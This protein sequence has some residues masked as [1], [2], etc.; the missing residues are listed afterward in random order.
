VAWVEVVAQSPRGSASGD[1]DWEWLVH[2]I[3]LS[4]AIVDSGSMNEGLAVYLIWL[5]K[6]VRGQAMSSVTVRMTGFAL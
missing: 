5:E 4:R 6:C 3:P 1:F 2:V